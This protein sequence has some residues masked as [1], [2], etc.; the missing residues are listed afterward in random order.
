V[1]KRPDWLETSHKAAV[2]IR[3]ILTEI[4]WCVFYVLLIIQMLS[5]M[6]PVSPIHV[7]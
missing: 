2:K 1:R 5:T 3:K 7:A 6:V 4:V